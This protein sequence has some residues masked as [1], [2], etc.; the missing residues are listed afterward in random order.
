MYDETE[1]E[2][3]ELAGSLL[4]AHPHLTD[5]NFKQSVVLMTAHNDDGSVGVVINRSLNL[6]LKDVNSEFADYGLENVPLY[7]GGPVNENQIL[8][9][10]WELLTD[11]N[12]FKLYFGMRPEEAQKRALELS[13][14][15]I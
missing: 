15:H 13:L 12:E 9:A 10:A 8:L 3:I 1:D 5:P 4:L 2:E 7:Y 11:S 6:T 14:I